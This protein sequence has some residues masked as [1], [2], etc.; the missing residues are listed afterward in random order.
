MAVVALFG[1]DWPC[2]FVR[3]QSMPISRGIPSSTRQKGRS[4]ERSHVLMP[5]HQLLSTGT[6]RLDP[7]F[8]S[9]GRMLQQALGCC[10]G[11]A[12]DA[13]PRSLCNGQV[14]A[15]VFVDPMSLAALSL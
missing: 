1:M 7:V 11:G 14:P 13:L 2:G 4:L 6:V 9:A 5:P 8:A 10:T 12:A 3:R 15:F